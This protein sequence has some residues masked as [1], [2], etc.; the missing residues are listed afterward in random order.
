METIRIKNVR[1]HA[2][3][4]NFQIEVQ[5]RNTRLLQQALGVVSGYRV[6]VWRRQWL[7]VGIAL[8]GVQFRANRH[9]HDAQFF[10]ILVQFVRQLNHGAYRFL[11]VVVRT[12]RSNGKSQRHADQQN[13]RLRRR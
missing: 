13:A 8:L 4:A 5:H 7:V 3:A 2:P 11:D 10:A 9:A 6:F 1:L 12:R